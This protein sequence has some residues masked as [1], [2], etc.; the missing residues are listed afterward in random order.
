MSVFAAVDIGSNPV[1]LKIARVV[2]HRLQ[3]IHEGRTVTRLGE[4]AFRSGILA[5]QAMGATVL[6][7]E[8]DEWIPRAVVLLR[9]SQDRRQAALPA[10]GVHE[11]FVKSNRRRFL[12]PGTT[13]RI[14]P[15]S[16]DLP[17]MT[18]RPKGD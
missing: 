14:N 1:R 4:S 7:G 8:D 18:N 16:P 10:S 6:S 11:G 5:P 2:G 15:T 13:S 3:T 17:Q 9:Y 12:K